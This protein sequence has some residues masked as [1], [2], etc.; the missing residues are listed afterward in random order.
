MT[1]PPVTENTVKTPRHT[2]FYL[3]CGAKDAPLIIFIHGW[4]ELS[5][6]WHH[7][8]RCFGALGFRAVAP[9]MRGY[10]RSS[11]YSHHDEDYAI[12][13][14]VKD[15]LDFLDKIGVEKAIWIGHDW[16]SM[17]V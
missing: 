1:F 12:E 6:S 13:H 3:A 15:M 17:V 8:L 7:Q 9:D 4:P 5:I 16:G 11:V 10:G 2:S 14:M